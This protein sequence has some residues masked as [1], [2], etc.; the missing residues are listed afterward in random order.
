[1]EVVLR[2]VC[3]EQFILL[4]DDAARYLA[5]RLPRTFAAAH[6]MAAALDADLVKGAKPVALKAARLALEKAQAV[7]GVGDG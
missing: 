4:S 3:R 2:R 1:M 7:W 6:Q 5:R